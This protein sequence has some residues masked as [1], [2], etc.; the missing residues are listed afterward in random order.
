MKKTGKIIKKIVI[1]LAAILSVAPLSFTNVFA[2]DMNMPKPII[3]QTEDSSGVYSLDFSKATYTSKSL[4]VNGQAVNY[5]AYEGIVYVQHPVDTTYESMNIYIPEE[6]FEDGTIN[7]YT[8]Q[9]AP[10]FFPNSI[11]GYMPGAAGSP[12]IGEEIGGGAGAAQIGASGGPNAALYALSQ[13]YVVAEPGARGRTNKDSSGNYY[14]K[15][16]ACIVDLKAAVRYLRYNDKIMPGDA[17]KIISDGT[18]AGG[19]VSALLGATGDSPDYKPYLEALGAADERDDIF[20]TM[21]YCP[22]TNLDNADSAYEWQFNGINDYDSMNISFD[23]GQI[24]RTMVHNTMT[25]SQIKLSDELKTLFPDYVNSLGLTSSEGAKLSLDADGN[26]SF[27]DY[28]E[29]YVI[30]S[31]QKALDSGADMSSYTWL[32]ISDGKV[33]GI[34][35]EEYVKYMT[36]MKAAPSFDDVGLT[37]AENNE[38][39]TSTVDAQHFTQFGQENSTVEGNIADASIIKMMNPMNY[40]GASGVTTSPYWRIRYGTKDSN[41]GLAVPV[42]LATELENKDYNVDFAMPWDVGHGGD[43]DL[44]ELFAWADSICGTSTATPSTAAVQVSG[45]NV[46]FDTYKVNGETYFKLRDLAKAL[47]GSSKQFGLS[48]DATSDSISLNSGKAYTSVG[49]ELSGMQGTS[50]Q[51]VENPSLKLRVN[52]VE[53]E[54]LAVNINGSNYIQLVDFAKLLDVNAIWN[55]G[56]S[57]GSIDTNKPYSY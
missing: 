22:I 41:T 34:N 57:T 11:G 15:A 8:S 9:T 49:G 30:A 31:A 53:K 37:A 45:K 39:G 56:K 43:Y 50:A 33:T 47:S 17:E 18:S 28:V 51:V 24:T 14:G 7:G 20:A 25:D 26:G 52:G 2:G 23:N 13:G 5:R 27:K 35:F 19:A 42:I 4:T 46:S 3:Q 10:I 36:R 6:Y 32:T 16:P 21:A 48:Y 54:I 44:H 55:D 12:S 40:I 29:S 38:F 1:P